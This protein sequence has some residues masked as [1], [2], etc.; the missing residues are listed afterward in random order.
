LKGYASLGLVSPTTWNWLEVGNWLGT[1][2]EVSTLISEVNHLQ[3]F[4]ESIEREL[5]KIKGFQ[6]LEPDYKVTKRPLISRFANPSWS[7]LA[8]CAQN[9]TITQNPAGNWVLILSTSI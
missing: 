9:E 8:D 4:Q 6:W 7:T 5:M 3:V 2:F 1:S